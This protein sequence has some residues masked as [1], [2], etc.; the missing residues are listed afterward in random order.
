MISDTMEIFVVSGVAGFLA[1][2]L[3]YMVIPAIIKKYA[4][5]FEPDTLKKIDEYIDEMR[6]IKKH[7]DFDKKNED[8]VE[9]ILKYAD[10]AITAARQ[11]LDGE[12][13][14]KKKEYAIDLAKTMV[15]RYKISRGEDKELSHE[16]TVI[17]NGMIETAIDS[18]KP[19]NDR[20]RKTK[21]MKKSKE[22]SDVKPID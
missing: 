20:E 22:I 11:E 2:V 7:F 16:E 6:D 19:V 1:S 15:A 13:N 4:N 17:I 8:I 21:K 12:D 5:K 3:F 18:A 14:K 10:Y 9:K